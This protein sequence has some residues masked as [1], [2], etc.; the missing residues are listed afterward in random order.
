MAAIVN[1]TMSGTVKMMKAMCAKVQEQQEQLFERDCEIERLRK[2]MKDKVKGRI[3]KILSFFHNC[4]LQNL[5]QILLS[6]RVMKCREPFTKAPRL[7]FATSSRVPI[8]T[9]YTNKSGALRLCPAR[10][11]RL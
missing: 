6:R 7:L 10:P 8:P 2:Q 4:N 5:S 1:K 11:S 3:Y 9:T